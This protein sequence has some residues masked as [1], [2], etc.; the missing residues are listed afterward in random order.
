MDAITIHDVVE[1]MS[2]VID[3]V[4]EN[5]IYFSELDSAAGDGD[6]GSS[7][8]KGFREVK[9]EWDNLDTN[10]I[11]VFMK[12]CSMIIMDKCGG[13]SGPIWGTAFRQAGNYAKGK[14]QL[15]LDELASFFY[16][17]VDGVKK[18]GGADLG[19]KTLLDAF[20]PAAEALR[21][22]AAA[23]DNILTALKKCVK[24][25]EDGANNTKQISARKGRASYLGERSIG[26]YDAGAKAV[27][28]ILA[29]VVEKMSNK[30]SSA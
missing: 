11:G 20:I 24:A 29:T 17:M 1:G 26:Y 16:A 5:E 8:A 22:S 30:R 27:A 7:L 13:A 9:S 15:D 25:A 23:H 18:V 19:D 4:I 14:K 12:S 28:V 10:D 21:T 3:T 6:F 2:V